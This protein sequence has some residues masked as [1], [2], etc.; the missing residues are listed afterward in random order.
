MF[1]IEETMLGKGVSFLQSPNDARLSQAHLVNK[2][3]RL[4][5]RRTVNQRQ[6]HREAGTMALLAPR[7]NRCRRADVNPPAR[8]SIDPGPVPAP[9]VRFTEVPARQKRLNT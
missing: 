4:A 6:V 8:Q 5:Q 7:P 9:G 1:T 2:N 3:R